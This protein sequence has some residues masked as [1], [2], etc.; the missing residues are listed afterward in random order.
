MSTAF[1][2]SEQH[3]DLSAKLVVALERISE[4]YK[5]MLWDQAKDLGLSPIQI[6]I[7]I[8]VAHHE[9]RLCTVSHIAREFNLTKATISDAIRVLRK[10]DLLIKIDSEKDRRAYFLQLSD[11]AKSVVEQA[12]KYPDAIQEL[13][14]EM[15]EVQQGRL[16]KNLSH[17][18]EGL[19]Q[20]EIIQVQRHC[21][22]CKYLE[23]GS[24]DS[25]CKLLEKNLA[26]HE[27]RLDCPEF[28]ALD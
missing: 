4:A 9:Q 2:P 17:L 13:I 11:S 15:P 1:D 22:A 5:T 27:L 24:P 18:I 6:Q 25:Y 16:F 19:V 8:F 23:K 3:T 20:K 14:R 26:Q 10:K 21:Q 7:L 28:E 12:E